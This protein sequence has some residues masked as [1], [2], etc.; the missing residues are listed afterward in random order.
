[1]KSI[2]K[3]LTC[4]PWVEDVP[5]CCIW[6]G[7]CSLMCCGRQ[8]P[9]CWVCSWANTCSHN[10]RFQIYSTKIR[11]LLYLK[12]IYSK[13]SLYNVVNMNTQTFFRASINQIEHLALLNQAKT[14]ACFSRFKAPL[15]RDQWSFQ[16]YLYLL[17][18]PRHADDL[19]GLLQLQ[20]SGSPLCFH[21]E[22][23][24][25][26]GGHVSLRLVG[27]LALWAGWGRCGSGGQWSRSC[28]NWCNSLLGG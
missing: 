3:C 1:M 5:V 25:G 12:N 10:T 9:L 4:P 22:R 7:S 14:L 24:G 27:Q 6:I 19:W 21:L 13:H 8:P 26:L 23:S 15:T 18:Q 2:S 11:F 20:L 17:L 16:S 28:L